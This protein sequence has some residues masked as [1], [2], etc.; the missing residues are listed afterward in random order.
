LDENFCKQKQ[1][2]ENYANTVMILQ[3]FNG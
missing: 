1:K 2:E 3:K